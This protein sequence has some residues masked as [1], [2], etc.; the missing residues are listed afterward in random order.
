MFDYMSALSAAFSLAGT[1]TSAGLSVE[2]N[3]NKKNELDRQTGESNHFYNEQIYQNP[4]QRYDCARSF[5]GM[6]RNLKRNNAVHDRKARIMGGTEEGNM[7]NRKYNADAIASV[8]ETVMGQQA[9][10]TDLLNSQKR[11]ENRA[12]NNQRLDLINDRLNTYGN[13]AYN[14]GNS[15]AGFFDNSSVDNSS[16]D[17][18]VKMNVPAPETDGTLVDPLSYKGVSQTPDG[19]YIS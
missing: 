8:E 12:Y 19:Y 1:A 16:V 13:L 9:K 11:A 10:R 4:L 15:F 6:R 18:S 5:N 14:A 3:K 7:A 17:N 2:T